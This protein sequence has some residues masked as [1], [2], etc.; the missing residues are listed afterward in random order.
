M[1]VKGCDSAV[2]A[3]DEKFGMENALN[4]EEDTVF[5]SKTNSGTGGLDSLVGVLNLEKPSLV[6]G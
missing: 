6:P 4:T 1:F 2:R 3:F 5:A